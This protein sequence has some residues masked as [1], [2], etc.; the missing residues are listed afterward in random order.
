MTART[1]RERTPFSS[2]RMRLEV[3]WRDPEK[4]KNFV[5]RWFNDVDGRVARA[6]DGG[7]E[8]VKPEEVVGVGDSEVHGG[9]TDLN[10][11]VSRVVGRAEGNIPIRGFLMK[12]KKSWYDKDQKVK[13]RKNALVDQAIRSGSSGGASIENKYGNVNLS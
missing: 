7:Y 9:N 3:N 13:A 10:S 6:L 2:S 12:I 5:A 11:R 8:Y 4:Q 1:H